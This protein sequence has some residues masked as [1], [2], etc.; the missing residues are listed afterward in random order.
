MDVTTLLRYNEGKTFEFKR[1]VSSPSKIINT[2][3]AF[4][5]TAGGTILVGIDE[6]RE[7]CGID[8]PLSTEERLANLIT[9]SIE[10]LI[11][12]NIHVLNVRDRAVIAIEIALSSLRPH[13]LKKTGMQQGTYVRVGSTNRK[14]DNA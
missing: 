6:S 3:V 11:I 13:Y 7:I 1:D 5:N 9:D 10:P 14:A 12:P 8:D 2:I 4:A